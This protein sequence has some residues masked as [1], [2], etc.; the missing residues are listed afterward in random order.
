MS[1]RTREMA[2]RSC[3]LHMCT[4]CSA[5]VLVPGELQTSA[6][7]TDASEAFPTWLCVTWPKQLCVADALGHM[8]SAV[9]RFGL[10]DFR[11]GIQGRAP[12]LLLPV[13]LLLLPPPT[14]TTNSHT[15]APLLLL[16][17][18]LP[19]LAVSCSI[20]S[21]RLSCFHKCSCHG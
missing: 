19:Q 16:V 13:L 17:L 12:L 11:Y 3:L 10:L 6:L 8:L 5:E 21:S 14:T 18:L 1:P 20:P 15:A 7:E 4:E 9:G 2:L